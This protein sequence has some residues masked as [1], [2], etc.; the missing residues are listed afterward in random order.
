MH[1][2]QRQF[3]KPNRTGAIMVLATILLA[4]FFLAAAFALDL[5]RVQLAETEMRSA[6][7]A[8][9]RAGAEALAQGASQ[10]DVRNE[11]KSI[12][13]ANTV[14]GE[15]LEISDSDIHLGR[16][17]PDELGKYSF[18]DGETPF[19]SVRVIARR[20]GNLG[21]NPIAPILGQLFGRSGYAIERPA[22]AV[23][24]N[25]DIALV[26]DRS[27]SMDENDGGKH[28]ISGEKLRRIEAVKFA[29]GLFRAVIDSTRG[30]E[31]LGLAQYDRDAQTAA[32][33][34]IN[35][36]AF[37]AAIQAMSLGSGTNI[38]AGID[39][40]L[41][42]LQNHRSSATPVMIVLTDGEHN[43]FPRSG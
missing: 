13:L 3:G 39:E 33:L 11:I 41:E 35:Y 26:V 31:S 14:A 34:D 10:S 12:G 18:S 22:A 43:G 5:A 27:S 6:I 30:D 37:D 9:T 25:R 19:N 28:P 2:K 8:A 24:Q 1:A 36:G 21:S 7:D 23:V 15:P 16:A 17:T 38:G 4:A 32:S 40:G 42:I 20:S 29:V